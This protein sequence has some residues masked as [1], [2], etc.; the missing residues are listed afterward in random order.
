MKRLKVYFSQ[1]PAYSIVVIGEYVL[2][3]F[4][5]EIKDVAKG[6]IT[7]DSNKKLDLLSSISKEFNLYI[8]APIIT[9][10]K[11]KIFKKMAL[12]T[13][14]KTYFYTQQRLINF[15]HWDEASFFDN[16]ASTLKTPLIF[17][18]NGLKFALL[19][20]YELHFD[21]L[22]LKLKNA[23][24]DAILLPCV[25]T[26]ESKARWK[27]LIKVRSFLNTCYI[28]RVNRV[29]S[30]KYIDGNIWEFYGNSL[31]ALGGEIVNELGDKEGMLCVDI[32]SKSLNEVK[33][34]WS[35]KKESLT[36]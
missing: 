16:S 8:V 22:T 31:G 24:V 13:P 19:F 2:D 14:M 35:F 4:F 21:E 7:N 1:L 11:D 28:F 18:A 32:D 26:F 5:T 30:V 17:D 25:N 6:I 9:G 20:G 23:D 12:I 34:Q 33:S 27:E 3:L 10:S 36:N 15:P 29:G